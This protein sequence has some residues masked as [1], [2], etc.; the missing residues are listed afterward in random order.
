MKTLSELLAQYHQTG[1]CLI[2][3]NFND[4]WDVQAICL[5]AQERNQPV[6]LMAYT[7]VVE[8]LGLDLIQA[9]VERMKARYSVPIYL[10]LDHCDDVEMCM[11]AVDVGFDSVM[12]DGS[13][14]A[15]EENIERTLKVVNYAHAKGAVVEAEIGKIRGRG[16]T[17]DDY[18]ASVTD[19]KR[20][21]EETNVDMI[22]VGIGTAHGHYQGKP[23]INFERLQQIHQ[24]VN[25]PLVLHGGTGIPEEDIRHSMSLGITKINVGTAIHTTY[26]QGLGQQIIKD[27]MDAYPP[28]TIGEILPQIKNEVEKY[29]EM[30]NPSQGI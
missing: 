22:A 11:Q 3:F 27:G 14:L 5:A 23:E 15:L 13:A 17:D 10:H 18:L 2:G 19:V 29:F 25:T 20:L 7:K 16:M 21:A 24:A 12:I 1:E 4:V 28:T 26:M 30:V 9:I 6:M 8:V